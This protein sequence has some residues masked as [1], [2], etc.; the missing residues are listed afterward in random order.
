MRITAPRTPLESTAADLL[1]VAVTHPVKLAGELAALDKQLGGR[2]KQLVDAGEIRGKLNGVTVIHTGGTEIKAAR[3]AVVGLGST[4]KLGGDEVRSAFGALT[5]TAANV[6]ARSV[7]VAVDTV[8]GDAADA[9]RYVIEGVSAADY[10]FDRY[11][12]QGK[13][14]R[15]QPLRSLALLGADR[16]ASRRTG[17]VAAAV[18]RARDLQNTPPNVL[19]PPELADR[20]RA[21]GREHA[22]VSTTIRDQRWIAANGM[23]AFAAVTQANDSPARLI[24]MRYRPERPRR[25]DVVLGL[26]GKGVTFDSGGLS[27]KPARSMI[28]MKYDMSGAAAVIEATAAI[29]ELK[30]AGPGGDG[31]RRDREPDRRAGLQGGRRAH[32]QERQDDRDHQHRRRGPAG[33][34]RLPAPRPQPGRDAR[35]RPGDAD[36]RGGARPGRYSTAGVMGRDQDWVDQVME[37]GEQS[38]DHLWQL[39]LHDTF[40]RYFRSDVADMANSSSLGLAGSSYAGRF[41]QEFAGEGPWAHLDIAG[42]ADLTRSRGDEFARGGTGYGVRLLVE[43]AQ[44]LC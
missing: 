29:A 25:R 44:S 23:G 7:A 20:A 2:I 24:T 22:R 14:D 12:T 42:T 13:A 34:G 38:G 43:L 36:R 41:L 31:R 11:R 39:P 28:G 27:I 37:A 5:R 10:R 1:A 30:P 9:T 32:G 6:R 3:I 17:V 35:G 40:L 8:P 16:A 33:A 18:S 26:V 19:G 15:P 4:E 21:I